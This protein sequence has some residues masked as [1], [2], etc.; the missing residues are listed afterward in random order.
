MKSVVS[1]G[2]LA[3]ML[4][5]CWG[6]A[7]RSAAE[8]A[9]SFT[10]R[11]DWFDRGN[12][13]ISTSG[14]DYADKYPCIWNAGQLPNQAEYDL[15]FPVAADYT[16]VA[17]YTAAGSRPVDIY[18]DGKKLH[19]GFAS[20]TGNWQTSHARWERQCTVHITQGKHTVNL[21]CPSCMPHICAL[22]FESPVP[23][24]AGWKLA[25]AVQRPR[26]KPAEPTV[27]QAHRLLASA[28]L[29]GGAELRTEVVRSGDD[30]GLD[31]ASRNELLQADA[32][33]EASMAPWVARISIRLPGGA[34]EGDVLA[35][36][37]ARIRK[38]L[39]H[40]DWLIADYRVVE[41]THAD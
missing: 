26:P 22:R 39:A 23:L 1:S 29:A 27:P 38:M 24:P 41:G 30:A 13:R 36:A 40:A 6:A 7:G 2:W 12:V 16:L 33:G 35:L 32:A 31:P 3:W 15:D 8:P 34:T 21:L 25:R 20:V 18:L 17:L 19:Q 14:Q 10:L 5:L 9:G 11:A 37:P 28:I 4:V